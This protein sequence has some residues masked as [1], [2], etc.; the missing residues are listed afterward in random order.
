LL[1]EQEQC[2]SC[3]LGQERLINFEL[4]DEMPH[5]EGGALIALKP[6]LGAGAT[7]LPAIATFWRTNGYCARKCGGH[8]LGRYQA[9]A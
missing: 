8:C 6:L 3:L 5:V 4:A 1:L 7:A 9:G 2:Q